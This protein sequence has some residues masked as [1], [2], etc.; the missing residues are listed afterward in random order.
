[1]QP[2]S[3]EALNALEEELQ[4]DR[5]RVSPKDEEWGIVRSWTVRNASDLYRPPPPK[6]VPPPDLRAK[7]ESLLIQSMKDD[8]ELMEERNRALRPRSSSREKSSRETLIKDLK[9]LGIRSKRRKK[10]S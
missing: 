9:A 7:Y 8:L 2:Y 3:E 6:R 4:N 10:T 1:M 5:N